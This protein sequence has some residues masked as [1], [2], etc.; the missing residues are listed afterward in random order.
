MELAI[1][2]V[3]VALLIGAGIGVFVVRRPHSKKV[4]RYAIS[5]EERE[6]L[7]VVELTIHTEDSRSSTFEFDPGYGHVLSDQLLTASAIAMKN[8]ASI[9]DSPRVAV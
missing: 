3:V 5:V 6:G 1:V 7:Q 8:A 2:G 4:E 9:K